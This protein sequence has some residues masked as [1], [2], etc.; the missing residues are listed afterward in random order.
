MHGAY[1]MHY[2]MTAFTG[3]I[4]VMCI[5]YCSR[6]V[7]IF[8]FFFFLL[9]LILTFGYSLPILLTDFIRSIYEGTSSRKF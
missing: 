1:R 5:H 8:G 3:Q 9:L 6:A 4:F 2:I 7:Y